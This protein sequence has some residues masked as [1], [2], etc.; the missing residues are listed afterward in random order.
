[1]GAEENG[2]GISNFAGQTFGIIGN[3]FQM[4]GR[5]GVDQRRR[6]IKLMHQDNGAE[7]AP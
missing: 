2:S 4:L 5:H 1:M 3:D 7:V 6:F